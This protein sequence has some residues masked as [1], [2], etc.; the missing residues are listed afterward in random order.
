MLKSC[1]NQDLETFSCSIWYK[2]L[3]ENYDSY[4]DNYHV[5]DG[6]QIS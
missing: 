5:T 1:K 2:R 3:S 4:F 6:L